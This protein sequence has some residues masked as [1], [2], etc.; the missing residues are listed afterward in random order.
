MKT[1]T[2]DKASNIVWR[3]LSSVK[4]TIALLIILALASLLGTFI[5]QGHDAMDFARRLSP[6]TLKLLTAL[7]LFDIYHSVWFKVLIILLSLNL[8]VCSIDR[9]PGAWKRFS[10]KPR[11]DRSKP[12]ETALP[13]H[14]FRVQAPL[15]S[16]AETAR[17]ALV[18]RYKNVSEKTGQDAAYFY[19]Q[20]GRYS[21]FG[22][23]L[24]HLSVL[25][26]LAGALIGSFLGF[27]GFVNILEGEEVSSIHERR[28]GR[29]IPLGFT[30]KCKDFDVEFYDDGT[31]K[32]YRSD[33]VF[34]EKGKVV[35][36]KSVLVN[37][38]VKFKGIMFYQS[39]YGQVMG[40]KV[41]LR[42]VRKASQ[43]V[44]TS[45]E[46]SR[47]QKVRVPDADAYFQVLDIREDFMRMGPAVLISVEN[48][49][50]EE[51][52]FWVFWHS[53]AIKRRFPG[54]MEQFQK[55]NPSSF[56]PYTFLLERMERIYYTGLQVNRDP[57]VPFVWSGFFMMVIG[58]FVAFFTSHKRIWIKVSQDKKGSRI[59]VAGM[60][61]KNP[62]GL[63]KELD[64][65]TGL[66]REQF[67]GG[68]G[69]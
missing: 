17:Q 34:L 27:E 49:G 11:P 55:L 44:A 39:S 35:F 58:L 22:V 7:D 52:R 62:V 23:Y 6:T 67:V 48:K 2:K 42:V 37:H 12:F 8:V 47:G 13:Q 61:N 32:E 24:V 65:V 10:A 63:H 45:I 36:E 33:L 20:R 50:K 46:V 29:H 19:C 40:D 26:I 3:A 9:F 1:D 30:V 69:K 14:S 18:K 57:G 51:K 53:E 5:P 15:A 68:Q 16:V 56:K 31:P 43:P 54:I 21:H 28:T 38:P 59:T 4:L 66:L 64:L 25:I 41:R 60:S